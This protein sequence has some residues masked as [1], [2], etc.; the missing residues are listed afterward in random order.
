MGN[1]GLFER[2]QP[3]MLLQRTS[4]MQCC[5]VRCIQNQHYCSYS[6]QRYN[7]IHWLQSCLGKAAAGGCPSAPGSGAGPRPVPASAS[8]AGA[9]QT[10]RCWWHP[11][12]RAG[13][14]EARFKARMRRPKHSDGSK[15]LKLEVRNSPNLNRSP[16]CS[17]RTKAS[18]EAPSENRSLKCASRSSK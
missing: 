3:G 14:P 9:T 11:P 6:M 15:T 18:V 2:L 12:K 4:P 17:S 1:N 10:S 13:K 16:K 8:G 5:S 7:R